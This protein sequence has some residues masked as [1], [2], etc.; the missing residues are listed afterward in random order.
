MRAGRAC[1]P[2]C[3]PRDCLG[4]CTSVCTRTHRRRLRSPPVAAALL[5]CESQAR[6]STPVPAAADTSAGVV[7]VEST[8]PAACLLGKTWGYDDKG[9]WV[10]DGCSGEFRWVSAAGGRAAPATAPASGSERADRTAIETLGR[11]RTR[12]TASSSGG[13]AC[14]RVGHQRLRAGAL[15]QPDAGRRRP[16]PIT[17][18]TRA[19]SMAATTSTRTGSWSSSRAGSATRS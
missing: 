1:W 17:S 13:T 16:S 6:A 5:V 10:A 15:H 19:P 3:S 2:S 14:R 12:A 11:V 7:L 9:V 4:G 8:G 18:G